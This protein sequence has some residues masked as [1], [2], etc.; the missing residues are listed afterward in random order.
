MKLSL[1]SDAT[2][3]YSEC[4]L[5]CF[6]S[7]KAIRD[8][9]F[10]CTDLN[11]P[12]QYV[13]TDPLGEGERMR[14]MLDEIELLPTTSHAN[15]PNPLKH[16]K[17]AKEIAESTLLF[18]QGASIPMTVVHPGA[19][20]GNT[21]EEFFERNVA[22]YR[23]LIPMAEQTGVTVLVENIGNYADPY[24]LRNGKEL[25][26]MLDR[27]DH[28]L[29]GACWDIGHANHFYP[30]DGNQY[31]SILALGK[32]LQAIH[33][34]D[35]VGCLTDTYRHI[36]L[37]MHTFPAF[38]G[39]ASV[40]WDAVMQGLKDVGYTGTFNFE[41]NAPSR[42]ECEPFL[43]NGE[44]LRRL[45]LMPLHVWKAFNKALFEMGKAMLEAYDLCENDT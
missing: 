33:A 9:G 14:A 6:D 16:P 27:I 43:H 38:S 2:S 5:S 32:R 13:L 22:F 11:I 10:S 35:N 37:D 31:D 8:C 23:S 1:S 26:E 18:C 24:F 20:R 34:H 19:I 25:S 4:G 45:E 3:K 12:A 15:P 28:P 29:F 44:V 42:S 36:R 21:R 40:N 39:A 41:V 7:L 30:K 17:E